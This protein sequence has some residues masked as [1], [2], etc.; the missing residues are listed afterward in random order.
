MILYNDIEIYTQQYYLNVSNFIEQCYEESSTRG[1][2]VI[3]PIKKVKR[4][5]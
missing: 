1:L 3:R 2:N 4:F 5:T